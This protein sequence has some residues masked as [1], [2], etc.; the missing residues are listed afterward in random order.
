MVRM[1]NGSDVTMDSAIHLAQEIAEDLR[2]LSVV[3]WQ[4][5]VAVAPGGYRDGLIYID[6]KDAEIP[7]SEAAV[8]LRQLQQVC[9][10]GVCAGGDRGRL[11]GSGET[12]AHCFH[13]NQ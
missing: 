1:V 4:N 8:E 3:S 12:F 13:R 11:A 2:I 6:E 9:A 5:W 10:P 7:G